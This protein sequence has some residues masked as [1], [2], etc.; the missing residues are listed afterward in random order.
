MIFTNP[1]KKDIKAIPWP[2]H[3]DALTENNINQIHDSMKER[4]VVGTHESDMIEVNN[5]TNNDAIAGTN[6]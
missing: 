2:A 5:S 4:V 3:S 1:E 6:K